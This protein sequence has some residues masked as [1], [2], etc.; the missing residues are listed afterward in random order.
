[1]RD[2]FLGLVLIGCY[3]NTH[4]DR[5]GDDGLVSGE[6]QP[7]IAGRSCKSR[8]IANIGAG[9][10]DGAGDDHLIAL[11]IHPCIP[12]AGKGEWFVVLQVNIVGGFFL[13]PAPFVKAVG[14]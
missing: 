14:K 6:E 5:C 13:R 10:D 8:Q 12:E 1:M 9:G 3:V 4:S 2:R 11:L 7:G